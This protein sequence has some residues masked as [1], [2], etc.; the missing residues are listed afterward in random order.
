MIYPPG[1]PLV[2]PGEIISQDV[3]EDIDF[4]IKNGSAI[5][6]DLDNGYIKIVDRVNWEKYE[7]E[8][9]DEF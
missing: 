4:Y 3:L 1:I 8:N 9:S 7:G 5:H 2:I 6:S